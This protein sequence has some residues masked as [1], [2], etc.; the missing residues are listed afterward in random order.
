MKVK[1]APSTAQQL[2]LLRE[3]FS[4]HYRAERSVSPLAR[5]TPLPSIAGFKGYAFSMAT[6]I[7][8][9]ELEKH[10]KAVSEIERMKEMNK[11]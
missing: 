6:I 1:S 4:A 7:A 5:K 11:P 2:G 10:N 8:A 3:A 9:Q